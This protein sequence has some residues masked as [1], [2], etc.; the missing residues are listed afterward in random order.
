[1]SDKIQHCF[2]TSCLMMFVLFL[3][4]KQLL[5]YLVL[6]SNIQCLSHWCGGFSN[7]CSSTLIY[8]L[9]C[10]IFICQ[11]GPAIAISIF[12]RE[13]KC[14]AFLFDQNLLDIKFLAF[15]VTYI[16]ILFFI[17]T[18]NIELVPSTTTLLVGRVQVSLSYSMSVWIP[19]PQPCG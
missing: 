5:N 14:S 9:I 4:S 8:F 1:M 16:F 6:C 7:R 12:P 15:S 10:F 2:N 17:Q 3:F 11:K 18:L 13:W 19:Q